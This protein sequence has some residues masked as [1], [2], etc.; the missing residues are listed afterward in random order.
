ME[1]GHILHA[2]LVF[3][4]V[5]CFSCCIIQNFQKRRKHK[6][7]T[8]PLFNIFWGYFFPPESWKYKVCMHFFSLWVLP[9]GIRPLCLLPFVQSPRLLM[10]AEPPTLTVYHS[11]PDWQPSADAALKGKD[12]TRPRILTG[13][14]HWQQQY[15]IKAGPEKN[16]LSTQINWQLLWWL[17]KNNFCHFFLTAKWQNS[18]LP[19]CQMWQ[20]VAFICWVWY[21]RECLVALN[22]LVYIITLASGRMRIFSY[23]FLNLERHWQNIWLWWTVHGSPYLSAL[24]TTS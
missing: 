3:Y 11:R 18:L 12:Q 10:Y 9:V 13:T 24:E 16:Y 5:V 15:V 21:Y 7:I 1:T 6:K 23:Y 14:N 8:E 20:F 4:S 2:F 22:K 17:K 19:G